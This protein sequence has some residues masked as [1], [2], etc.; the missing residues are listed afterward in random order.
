MQI[1]KKGIIQIFY[2]NNKSHIGQFS[3][4]CGRQQYWQEYPAIL[5]DFFLGSTNFPWASC[6]YWRCLGL[7]WL[8]SPLHYTVETDMI[9]CGS[10]LVAAACHASG[11]VISWPVAL[12]SKWAVL[13][14]W[15]LCHL[16]LFTASASHV[17][18]SMLHPFGVAL[19]SAMTS[20]SILAFCKMIPPR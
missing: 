17:A 9:L 5:M 14:W 1:N 16:D 3:K 13:L 11:R 2:L 18:G 20:S 10:G 19:R 15:T 7:W 6:R 12:P 4:Q 8:T